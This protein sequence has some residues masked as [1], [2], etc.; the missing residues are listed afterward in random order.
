MGGRLASTALG[1][2]MAI[3]V[4]L[5]T[6]MAAFAASPALSPAPSP[7][8]SPGPSP[9]ASDGDRRSGSNREI[10]GRAEYEL[11]SIEVAVR[12]LPPSGAPTP[13]PTVPGPGGGGGAPGGDPG[14]TG[15][16]TPTATAGESGD[17]EAYGD[18]RARDTSGMDVATI[19]GSELT[20]IE[21]G[22]AGGARHR[23]RR[24][25]ERAAT[26]E[27][28]Q[29]GAPAPAPAPAPL[30]APAPARSGG[31]PFTGADTRVLGI[32]AAGGVAAVIAGAA[33]LRLSSRRRRTQRPGRD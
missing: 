5:A 16:G 31:L 32:A 3:M 29:G 27:R 20:S 22:E 25:E 14:D 9:A 1:F 19:D 4:V 18:E 28:A 6:P 15:A 23:S 12:V 17:R 8:P 26:P 2:E 24:A 7:G 21:I 11:G 30:P 33:V 13:W 10:P